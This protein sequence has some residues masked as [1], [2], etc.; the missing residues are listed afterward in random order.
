MTLDLTPVTKQEAEMYYP[1]GADCV[2]CL[3]YCYWSDGRI[4][5]SWCRKNRLWKDLKPRG[6]PPY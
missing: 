5:C 6:E 3:Y 1:Y 4:V 2:M